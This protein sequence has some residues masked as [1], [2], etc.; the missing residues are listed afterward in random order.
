MSDKKYTH[1][2]FLQTT[3]NTEETLNVVTGERGGGFIKYKNFRVGCQRA[4]YHK[5]LLLANGKLSDVGHRV[6]VDI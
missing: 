2:S 6:E 4:G 1:A 3:N 5:H